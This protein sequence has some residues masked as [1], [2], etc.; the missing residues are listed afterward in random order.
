[1]RRTAESGATRIA[2]DLAYLALTAASIPFT[3]AEAAARS[4]ST[5][6]IE[7]RLR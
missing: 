5:V 1:V 4:G 7:A 3:L 2:K 6:M